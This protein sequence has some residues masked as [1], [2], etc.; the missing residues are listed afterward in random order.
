MFSILFS[1]LCVK[2][3]FF[4]FYGSI[5]FEGNIK[6]AKKVLGQPCLS[7]RGKLT[8][9]FGSKKNHPEFVLIIFYLQLIN[10]GQA[11]SSMADKTH[12]K[13]FS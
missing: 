3:I 5:G 9:C 2:S 8:R 1:F 13:L 7:S 11:D 10:S 12:G 6:Y 4:W